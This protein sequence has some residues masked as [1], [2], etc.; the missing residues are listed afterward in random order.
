MMGGIRGLMNR[1][2][3]VI[4]PR[5]EQVV[6]RGRARMVWKQ[7]VAEFGGGMFIL[8]TA[9]HFFRHPAEWRA[10]GSAV[11]NSFPRI[12]CVLRLGLGTLDV[13]HLLKPP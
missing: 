2:K 13:E 6:K 12:I 9:L 11:V 5:A 8:M 1:Y 7:G 3:R 4:R 10:W